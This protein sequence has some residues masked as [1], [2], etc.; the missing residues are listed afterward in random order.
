MYNFHSADLAQGSTFFTIHISFLP[1]PNKSH[2]FRQVYRKACTATVGSV[3][4][5][6]GAGGYGVIGNPP[7]PM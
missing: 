7:L 4:L 5:V 1:H 3:V 6:V 2:I